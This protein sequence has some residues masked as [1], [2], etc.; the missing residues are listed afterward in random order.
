MT[1]QDILQLIY[2]LRRNQISLDSEDDDLVDLFLKVLISKNKSLVDNNECCSKIYKDWFKDDTQEE[3]LDINKVEQYLNNIQTKLE[4]YKQLQTQH[5]QL[6]K[7]FDGCKHELDNKLS[8]YQVNEIVKEE[9]NKIWNQAIASSRITFRQNAKLQSEVIGLKN[10]IRDL[11][12]SGG[13]VPNVSCIL[14]VVRAFLHG[15]FT[16][17]GFYNLEWILNKDFNTKALTP[18]EFKKSFAVT[19]ANIGTTYYQIFLKKSHDWH[20]NTLYSL[21]TI[22][23]TIQLAIKLT[24][25][26]EDT[27]NFINFPTY[28]KTTRSFFP[29]INEQNQD[30]TNNQPY[31]GHL[32]HS[33]FNIVKRNNKIELDYS[34]QTL[35]NIP[36]DL[37]E[38]KTL[39]GFIKELCKVDEEQ[40]EIIEVAPTS[41]RL[42]EDNEKVLLIAE[43]QKLKEQIRDKSELIANRDITINN[44]IDISNNKDTELNNLRT[45]IQELTEHKNQ[46]DKLIQTLSEG[47]N[48]NLDDYPT[49]NRGQIDEINKKNIWKNNQIK[50][51]TDSLNLANTNLNNLREELNAVTEES[52]Q[53]HNLSILYKAE[54]DKFKQERDECRIKLAECDSF[55]IS[56]PLEETDDRKKSGITGLGANFGNMFKNLTRLRFVI[57]SIHTDYSN[58]VRSRSQTMANL[59]WFLNYFIDDTITILGNK[60]GD[61]E[62]AFLNK[63]KLNDTTL[64]GLRQKRSTDPGYN[65]EVDPQPPEK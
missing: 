61:K 50:E 37:V 43:N 57:N 53:N 35:N 59:G 17:M 25:S 56:N 45:Q 32:I 64:R 55:F 27:I 49:L 11:E 16:K 20:S 48:L 14:K 23:K 58:R 18:E 44:L 33:P 31:N 26:N 38:F 24:E 19:P 22:L 2:K 41:E 7:D 36:T 34:T 8:K 47:R 46:S 60:I 65:K 4:E 15:L 63:K 54:S 39:K 29:V 10:K 9:V 1:I 21:L 6:E 42:E 13:T 28:W 40:H 12:E 62:K 5:T 3:E 51:K 30:I 52:T